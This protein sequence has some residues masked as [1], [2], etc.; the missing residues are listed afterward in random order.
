[1]IEVRKKQGER[2]EALLRRFN[3]VI[4]DSGLLK[5]LK[6]TRFHLSP[7]SRRKKKETAIRKMMIRK[8]KNKYYI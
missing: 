2:A 4:Q 5:T 7:P 6:E 1:M 3:R 8:I